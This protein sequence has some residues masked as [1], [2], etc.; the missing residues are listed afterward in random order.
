MMRKTE[1]LDNSLKVLKDQIK[2]KRLKSAELK[3]KTKEAD[4][5]LSTIM[6][7]VEQLEHQKPELMMSFKEMLKTV[8]MEHETEQESRVWAPGPI[9]WYQ[10]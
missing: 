4:A 7:K 10:C 8:K 9:I 1:E 2:E 6:E 5:K 3:N